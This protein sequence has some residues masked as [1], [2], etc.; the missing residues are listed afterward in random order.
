[1]SPF[2]GVRLPNCCCFSWIDRLFWNVDR[3]YSRVFLFFSAVL[4]VDGVYFEILLALSFTRVSLSIHLLASIEW[5][6][7]HKHNF[8]QPK[9]S[10]IADSNS[11]SIVT[12]NYCIWLL[13][14][15]IK[16]FLF[17]VFFW[18]VVMAILKPLLQ[19]LFTLAIS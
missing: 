15:S 4:T 2:S 17:S 9:I 6:A 11:T 7:I 1:M 19:T 13:L 16:H 12:S 18:F 8:I 14:I 5:N 3:K 10:Q